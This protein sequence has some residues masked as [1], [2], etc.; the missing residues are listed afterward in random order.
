MTIYDELAT[1]LALA[2]ITKLHPLER[3]LA[4]IVLTVDPDKRDGCSFCSKVA[5]QVL[6]SL[7]EGP[8]LA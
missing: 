1:A 3:E 4:T 6:K 5:E 2:D 7:R 8:L